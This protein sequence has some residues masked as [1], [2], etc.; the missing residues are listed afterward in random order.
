MD[1]ECIE[2]GWSLLNNMAVWTCENGPNACRAILD[3]HWGS[4]NWQ[5]LL[6]LCKFLP[7]SHNHLP[8]FV[9]RCFSYEKPMPVG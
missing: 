9:P 3:D 7:A 4:L 2:G 5:K 8:N 1:G 6:G